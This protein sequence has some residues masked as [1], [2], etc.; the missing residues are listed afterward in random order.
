MTTAMVVQNFAG[1]VVR[2]SK[3]DPML[4]NKCFSGHVTGTPAYLNARIFRQADKNC[5]VHHDY[6]VLAS[7]ATKS[8]LK[9]QAQFE[10][11]KIVYR[12]Q[13][14]PTDEV[15]Q[16]TLFEPSF[17]LIVEDCHHSRLLLIEHIN[18]TAQHKPIVPKFPTMS[19]E[20]YLLDEPRRALYMPLFIASSCVGILYFLLFVLHTV[21]RSFSAT[22]R[23]FLLDVRRAEQYSQSTS[24]T[25][26]LI[27]TQQSLDFGRRGC[28][29]LGQTIGDTRIFREEQSLYYNPI[30]QPAYTRRYYTLRTSRPTIYTTAGRSMDKH[31][32]VIL[33]AYLAF[34][35][36]YTFLFTFSVAVSLIFSL[37]PTPKSAST[38]FEVRKPPVVTFS[39]NALPQ[40][41]NI[42]ISQEKPATR[43]IQR[44]RLS[45]RRLVGPI[46]R[47]KAEARLLESYAEQEL[48]RQLDYVS[49]MKDACQHAVGVEI[50]DAAREMKQLVSERLSIMRDTKQTHQKYDE[51]G[52]R[53]T[54]VLSIS[55]LLTKLTFSEQRLKLDRYRERME[56]Q[57][58][59]RHT[60]IYRKFHEFLERVHQSGWLRYA[61][62][63]VN[64]SD[65]VDY[66]TARMFNRHSQ[67][68]VVNLSFDQTRWISSL[69]GHYTSA[70]RSSGLDEK[71]VK[72]MAF[73]GFHQ[74]ESVH[75]I[76]LQLLNEL[77]RT[78]LTNQYQPEPPTPSKQHEGRATDDER[79]SVK[80]DRVTR[81]FVAEPVVERTFFSNSDSDFI[82]V[83]DGLTSSLRMTLV[84]DNIPRRSADHYDSNTFENRTFHLNRHETKLT[85]FS[86]TEIRLLLL[87]IDCLIIAYR[88][89]HTYLILR[90]IWFGQKMFIDASSV[91]SFPS[92]S[93]A[94]PK[95]V[96]PFHEFRTPNLEF[97]SNRMSLGENEADKKRRKFVLRNFTPVSERKEALSTAAL[98]D[99]FS[100][101]ENRYECLHENTENERD[102]S[103][104][105]TSETRKQT[106]SS[107]PNPNT[108][109]SVSDMGS[110]DGR[111]SSPLVNLVPSS[112]EVS[113]EPGLIFPPPPAFES[114]QN[115][116]CL[117][118]IR[119]T[120]C[121]HAHYLSA[122]VGVT[123]ILVLFG[124]LVIQEQR[125][126][127]Q[128]TT[129]R[130][131]H[132]PSRISRVV[133]PLYRAQKHYDAMIVRQS[134]RLNSDW[135]SWTQ[136]KELLMRKRLLTYAAR[137]RHDFDDSIGRTNLMFI[138]EV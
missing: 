55:A 6:L 124:L 47:L 88:F 3:D 133:H 12:I 18:L 132:G 73:M 130:T 83:D 30:I 125:G 19:H 94:L 76:P 95:N 54:D 42:P 51:L 138:R 91:V 90:Q 69:Q 110:N 63:M 107:Q 89:Y 99:E 13:T 109:L 52:K 4:V 1:N 28:I 82:E 26:Q 43:A 131:H 62:R 5:L 137:F 79:T 114:H 49:R 126:F 33:F 24:M 86:L 35:V 105:P 93:F 77:K 2:N 106:G 72:L 112:R 67:T 129:L 11:F 68:P 8:R 98:L 50:T 100:V 36:F 71:Q 136:S 127:N 34:R 41:D 80:L 53:Q 122:V 44:V 104:D 117:L 22:S 66:E 16:D 103:P 40:R 60:E 23:K 84:A 61:Q 17:R 96:H 121:R 21:L 111:C 37:Q 14:T 108:S 102:K 70:Q 56:Q 65:Q 116:G 46:L 134:E 7:N 115:L 9:S 123:V 85:A 15:E 101:G 25:R 45:K 64:T 135:M 78:F 119:A 20:E 120:C 38:P 48:R 59:F 81:R 32:R 58:D 92:T 87:A 31:R 75:L 113:S 29:H 128:Q 118:G 10:Q 74:A 27:L 57:M 39:D 97:R